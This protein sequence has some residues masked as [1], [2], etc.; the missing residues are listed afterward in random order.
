MFSRCPIPSVVVQY[1][2]WSIG[3]KV[4]RG[5]ESQEGE[6]EKNP[7]EPGG[8]PRRP[9]GT[10]EKHSEEVDQRRDHN[11]AGRPEMDVA[12]QPPQPYLGLQILQTRI[13]L[14]RR[15]SVVESEHDPG[16]HE[17]HAQEVGGPAKGVLP[18]HVS[19]NPPVHGRLP[20]FLQGKAILDRPVDQAKE[21]G[22]GQEACVGGFGQPTEGSSP[23]GVL[24]R[25]RHVPLPMLTTPSLIRTGYRRRD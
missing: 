18:S 4:S 13:G 23:D 11:Q 2:H 3:K 9:V 10:R 24:L 21:P 6:K 20:G 25:P 22:D 17:D 8:L 5:H 19:W 14:N 12:N 15:G 1:A 7:Q 16:R